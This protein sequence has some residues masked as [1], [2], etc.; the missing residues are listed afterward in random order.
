ME[1]ENGQLKS[2]MEAIENLNIDFKSKIDHLT[3]SIIESN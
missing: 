2:E 3:K 1:L